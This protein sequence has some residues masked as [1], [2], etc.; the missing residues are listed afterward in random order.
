MLLKPAYSE[1]QKSRSAALKQAGTHGAVSPGR[2]GA[3]AGKTMRQ[4]RYFYLRIGLAP[5]TTRIHP[6]YLAGHS[7][8]FHHWLTIKAEAAQDLR[9]GLLRQKAYYNN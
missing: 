8:H 7:M 1:V 9:K 5:F 2:G 4:R 6:A 3:G